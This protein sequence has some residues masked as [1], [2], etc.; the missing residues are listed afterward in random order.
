ME[1]SF[2]FQCS[3]TQKLLNRI[4]QI[5]LEFPKLLKALF[6]VSVLI[7]GNYIFVLYSFRQYEYQ[8]HNM[9]YETCFHINIIF[10]HKLFSEW[11][12]IL[13]TYVRIYFWTVD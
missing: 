11:I 6:P 4:N 12:L 1:I 7:K 2:Y 8:G 3:P 10:T 13:F 5:A 9:Y